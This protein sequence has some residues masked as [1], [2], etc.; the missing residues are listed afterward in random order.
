MQ[1]VE[2][3]IKGNAPEDRIYRATCGHCSSLLQ[4]K[5]SEATFTSDQRDGD[6]VSVS[7]PVCNSSVNVAANSYQNKPFSN[8]DIK[9]QTGGW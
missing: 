6:Y 3:V 7:C 4:F 2:V 5:Q 1:M 8:A 9:R